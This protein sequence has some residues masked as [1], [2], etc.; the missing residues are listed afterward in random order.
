MTVEN[1]CFQRQSVL[2]FIRIIKSPRKNVVDPAGSDPQPPD[3]QS[4]EQ[5][6]E[7]LRTAAMKT[8]VRVNWKLSEV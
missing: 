5:P 6:T 3:H 7:P 2:T 1:I 8:V 4:E